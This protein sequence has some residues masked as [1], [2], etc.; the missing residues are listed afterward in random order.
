MLNRTELDSV[1]V[2]KVVII[3]RNGK[4]K[5]F[6]TLFE[7]P[8]ATYTS[9][10]IIEELDELYTKSSTI[11]TFRFN[12]ETWVRVYGK[13]Y[14]YQSTQTQRCPNPK[15]TTYKQKTFNIKYINW[16]NEHSQKEFNIRFSLNDIDINTRKSPIPIPQHLSKSQYKKYLYCIKNGLKFKTMIDTSY[17]NEKYS[18]W[19]GN[20]Q[21]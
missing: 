6:H 8:K 7:I 10:Y 3:N 4:I 9:T 2:I 5:P 14:A 12:K 15:S 1:R 11:L 18:F 21:I 16:V 17:P 20:Q 13:W 19:L